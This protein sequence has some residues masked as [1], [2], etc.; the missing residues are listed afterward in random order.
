MLHRMIGAAL[1]V[2][3]LMGAQAAGATT[4]VLANNPAPGD[5]FTNA[6]GLNQGQA[7]GA[8]DWYYN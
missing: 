5:A 4:I 8:T 3:T 2:G 1:V 7:I 6:G